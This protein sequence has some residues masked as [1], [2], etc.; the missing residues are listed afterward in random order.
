MACRIGITT[1]LAAR[2]AYW[3]SQHPTMKDWQILAGPTTRAVAQATETQ[4]AAQ[5]GCKA[6]PGGNE[7]DN[8][9]SQWYVYGFN[10]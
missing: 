1:D 4:L 9:S 8:G 7:P 5:N 10:Y 3:Q 6:S 2:K